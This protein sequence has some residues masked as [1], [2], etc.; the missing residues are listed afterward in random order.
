M[1][2]C[3]VGHDVARMF[4]RVQAGNQGD[5][6]RVYLVYSVCLVYLMDPF[7]PGTRVQSCW[8]SME[9]RLLGGS[10]GALL[11]LVLRCRKMNR[12]M[13]IDG[14]I[15]HARRLA[16]ARQTHTPPVLHAAC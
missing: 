13:R 1:L 9:R 4:S 10:P 6:K 14:S 7:L 15:P 16:H 5:D 3:A 2:C 11:D 12:E 8:V